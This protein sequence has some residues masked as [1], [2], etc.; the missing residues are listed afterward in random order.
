MLEREAAE[1]ARRKREEEE[2]KEKALREEMER[3]RAAREAEQRRLRLEQERIRLAKL[4]PLL[5]WLDGFP[6]P[7]TRAVAAKF[8]TMQGVRY[9][10][11]R[12]EANGTPDGREQWLLNTQVAL[13]LG[14][15]DLE[16]SKCESSSGQERV[17]AWA[18]QV[19]TDTGWTRMPVSDIAKRIIWR[20]E[21]DRYAL[22]SPSLYELGKQL[23][24]YYGQEDPEQ[25][26]YRAIEKLRG[27]AWEK[28]MAMDMFFVKVRRAGFPTLD[29]EIAD[30]GC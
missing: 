30:M 23:A 27:E 6:N 29:F 16:L 9:D 15:K 11:I 25:M 24:G 18:D 13:L 26:S 21:S 5:R 17:G 20:L 10:C 3:R 28:F 14:E 19:R 2:R 12:P 22:T 4:P 7:Q 1:E 8:A